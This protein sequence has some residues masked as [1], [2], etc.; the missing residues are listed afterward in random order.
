MA[1]SSTTLVG[2]AP[3]SGLTFEASSVLTASI[4]CAV[5]GLEIM[6]L[7]QWRHGGELMAAHEHVVH[8]G[9]GVGHVVDHDARSTRP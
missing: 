8:A 6:R 7:L 5:L 2:P 9:D 4:S 1:M 3:S